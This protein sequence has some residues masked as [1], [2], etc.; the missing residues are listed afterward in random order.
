VGDD[1][2]YIVLDLEWNQCPDGKLQEKKQ[3]PFEIIEIGAVKLN[4]KMEIID[5]FSEIIKPAVYREIHF[6]TREVIHI[7]K[8]EL[9]SGTTF[10]DAVTK[11]M[12][13]CGKRYQFCTWGTMD[14]VELQRN[15]K[16]Y[17]LGELLKSPM[18]YYDIQKIFSISYE[19]R[20]SR[21]TLEYAVDYLGIE[22][23]IEFHRAFTDA[24]YTAEIMRHLE[25]KAIWKNY[26]IDF[27]NN[28]KTR[29]EEIHVVYDTHSKY[30]SREF[31]KKE[32]AMADREVTSTRCYIC[33]KNARKKIRWFTSNTKSYY[34]LAY[35][36]THGY[37]KGFIS[38]KKTDGG[39]LFC[40]KKLGLVDLIEAEK[41]REK[42]E[43]IR[44][45]RRIKRRKEKEVNT[46]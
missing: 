37:L 43:S 39:K 44:N 27:Y 24:Y 14:L 42:R 19:D 40:V 36:E 45:K 2:K 31:E 38:I 33:G 9:K 32:L 41:V 8:E 3:L 4:D 46:R 10:V 28:P 13:W 17:H 21:R 23:N 12:K 30:I 7:E 29:K 20:K 6:R 11:F 15:L 1:M 35:C 26:S 25:R 18:N 16:Y 34:C 22:K 5:T